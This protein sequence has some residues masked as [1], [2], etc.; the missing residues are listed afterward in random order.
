MSD[1][2]VSVSPSAVLVLCGKR[3]SGKDYVA[4]QLRQL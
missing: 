2:G 1:S 4:D 3:K